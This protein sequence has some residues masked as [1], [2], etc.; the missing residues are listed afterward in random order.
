MLASRL[1]SILM[2]LQT[3]GRVT[4]TELATEFEVSVRTIHRDIDRLSAAGVPVYANRGRDGG[5]LLRD[6]YRT[7]LTGLTQREAEA[8]FLTGLPGPAEQLGMAGILSSARLKLMA[9]LPANIQHGAEKVAA[10]FHLDAAGWFRGTDL[11]P[12]LQMVATA[13]WSDRLLKL[14]YQRS[15]E[16]NP[17]LRTLAPLG[18]VLKGGVWYLVA[19][20]GNSIRTFRAAKLS[21]VEISDKTFDRPKK[22]DLATHWATAARDYEAGVYRE[23]AEVR[24]SPRGMELLELLGPHVVEAA[25]RTGRKPD[26][27]GWVRCTLPI[28]SMDSGVRELMRL[29]EEVGVIGPPALCSL[30]AVTSARVAGIHASGAALGTRDSGMRNT[31]NRQNPALAGRQTPI[32][33]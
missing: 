22:F 26:R 11:L 5:F 12:S 23:H 24:L 7:T 6:G 2:L 25:A 27:A 4:A 20:S 14:R 3:R 29:G 10:R 1:L 17:P 28:E 8:L 32:N 19:Q 21:D 30:L 16:S 31:R 33:S 15:G 13:V 9:A 18:L